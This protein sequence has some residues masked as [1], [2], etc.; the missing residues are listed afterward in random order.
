MLLYINER[1]TL[2]SLRLLVVCSIGLQTCYC[3]FDILARIIR[4]IAREPAVFAFREP[5]LLS[6]PSK[7]FPIIGIVTFDVQS[8]RTSLLI[9]WASE[10][11][12]IH[13]WFAALRVEPEAES[14]CCAA[15]VSI[16]TPPSITSAAMLG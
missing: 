14:Y 13:G 8:S 3:L 5:T 1:M 15:Q 11:T 16:S 6:V 12:T 2:H 10:P 9:P 4:Y 7:V